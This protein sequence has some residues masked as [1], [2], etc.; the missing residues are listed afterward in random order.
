MAKEDL[1]IQ[2]PGE[3]LIPKTVYK[4]DQWLDLQHSKLVRKIYGGSYADVMATAESGKDL[5]NEEKRTAYGETDGKSFVPYDT[6]LGN[7]F[8]AKIL[9]QYF[10]RKG[11]SEKAAEYQVE[12][13]NIGAVALAVQK[14]KFKLTGAHVIAIAGA[15][16]LGGVGISAIMSGGAGSAL[17]AADIAAT[18]MASGGG[19][20]A[21]ELATMGISTGMATSEVAAGLTMAGMTTAEITAGLT[22]AG[23]TE[24]ATVASVAGMGAPSAASA[25]IQGPATGFAGFDAT[26]T[27]VGE[28]APSATIGGATLIAPEVTGLATGMGGA[29]ISTAAPALASISA[30][31]SEVA[32]TLN[33]AGITSTAGG[34]SAAA[35]GVIQAGVEQIPPKA[36]GFVDSLIKG[37]GTALGVGLGAVIP[38]LISAYGTEA[39]KDA[40]A[41][42]PITSRVQTIKTVF[43]E[44]AELPTL[45]FPEFE[46]PK[47]EY[48]APTYREPVYDEMPPA[49]EAPPVDARAISAKAQEAEAAGTRRI[50]NAVQRA[51]N[52]GIEDPRAQA[53]AIEDILAGKGQAIAGVMAGAGQQAIQEQGVERGYGYTELVRNYNTKVQMVEEQRMSD[54]DAAQKTFM[55]L[56][57]AY[58]MRLASAQQKAQL[59]FTANIQKLSLEFEAQKQKYLLSG[60]KTITETYT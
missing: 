51:L 58:D 6:L 17:T 14:A 45:E 59:D 38:N 42:D 11:Y 36:S 40:F 10:M 41:P 30:V 22:A 60:T 4:P 21:A 43:P 52:Y 12:R 25:T 19:V 37:A 26:L 55:T 57:G 18:A 9:K 50:E 5:T 47:R 29:T 1:T 31:G 35:K 15:L 28:F 33:L 39:I 20:T 53:T 48:A 56:S 46:M 23:V 2:L 34:L 3:G 8:E 27:A 32:S 7:N 24:A 54:L 13:A 44:G 16:A 49:L